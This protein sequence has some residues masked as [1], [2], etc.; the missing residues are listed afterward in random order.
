MAVDGGRRRGRV[1]VEGGGVG[2]A[3]VA[4]GA[5]RG[6]AR[7]AA[8][9][10]GAR[11]HCG[12]RC[13]FAEGMSGQVI[14][15]RRWVGAGRGAVATVKEGDGARNF[16]WTRWSL[17]V[18]LGRGDGELAHVWRNSAGAC[19][20]IDRACAGIGDNPIQRYRRFGTVAH[21]NRMLDPLKSACSSQIAARQIVF[22]R[23]LAR[24]SR[25]ASSRRPSPRFVC[26]CDYRAP[27]ARSLLLSVGSEKNSNS[28]CRPN[29]H[30]TWKAMERV[31]HERAL[32]DFLGAAM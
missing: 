7:L 18:V 8:A 19:A 12:R 30:Q 21:P 4:C 10:G 5:G 20:R 3:A 22:G 29:H 24:A 14:S 1:G 32:R 31:S 6:G 27:S 2:H 23:R 15:G 25:S 11:T 16:S 26:P 17:S 9:R 28:R 13:G